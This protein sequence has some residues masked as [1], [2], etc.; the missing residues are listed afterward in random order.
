MT[1]NFFFSLWTLIFFLRNSSPGDFELTFPIAWSSRVD[2]GNFPYGELAR[3]TKF[4]RLPGNS[5]RFSFW[6]TSFMSSFTQTLSKKYYTVLLYTNS[7]R[8]QPISG[9]PLATNVWQKLAE[10]DPSTM[11]LAGIQSFVNIPIIFLLGGRLD[12]GAMP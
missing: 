2:S 10:T 12:A 6:T 9:F 5:Y 8:D 3:R 11:S 4:Q 1:I 7:K